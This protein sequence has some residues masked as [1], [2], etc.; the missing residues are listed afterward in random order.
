MLLPNEER[1]IARYSEMYGVDPYLIRAIRLAGNGTNGREY[2]VVDVNTHSKLDQLKVC[3]A[4]TRNSLVR[5][6]GRQLKM[7]YSNVGVK[8]IV[9]TAAF[10]KYLGESHGTDWSERVSFTY[11]AQVKDDG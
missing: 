2:G 9:Y 1:Q 3:C 6:K 10:L 11:Y 8:R 7:V 4:N 5:F